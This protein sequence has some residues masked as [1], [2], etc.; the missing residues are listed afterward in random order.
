MKTFVAII[1]PF[2]PGKA[3]QGLVTAACP[4]ITVT[5]VRG[6]GRQMGHA[7]LCRGDPC[8]IESLSKVMIEMVVNDT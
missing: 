5:E 8:F 1:K 6:F 7:E 2:K 4:G 3:R